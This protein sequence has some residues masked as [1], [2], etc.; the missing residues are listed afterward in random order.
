MSLAYN[1]VRNHRG[2]I[3]AENREGAGAAFIIEL[4]MAQPNTSGDEREEA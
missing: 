3:R 4:P 2:N 1:I